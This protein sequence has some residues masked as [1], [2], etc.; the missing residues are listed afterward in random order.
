ML[1]LGAMG[2][3]SRTGFL[4]GVSLAQISEFSLILAAL[5]IGLG[6]IDAETSSVITLVAVITIA[7]S[8]YLTI[9]AHPL[10]EHLGRWLTIFERRIPHPEE[11][12]DEPD[13]A[14]TTEIIL[15]GFG[16][17]GSEIARHLR[18]RAW[19]LLVV[20]FDPYIV[21]SGRKAGLNIRYGDAHDPE[22]LTHLPLRD[23]KWVVSTAPEREVNLALLSALRLQGYTGK[24]ALRAHHAA[25]V[26]VL[27][28]AGAGLVLEPL[29][30]G[31]KKAADLLSAERE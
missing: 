14:H 8:T 20:D 23:A 1:I 17:Y 22:L 27:E 26:E 11:T 12:A 31:A 13:T 6:H 5:G 21:A 19:N 30:D 24:V 3:R 10:Y 15:F 16:R 28:G 29:R 4:T 18:D 25:D 9:Y 2:Y 7:L